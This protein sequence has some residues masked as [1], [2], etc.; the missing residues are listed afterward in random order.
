MAE[1][2]S[3]RFKIIAAVLLQTCLICLALFLIGKDLYANYKKLQI[4]RCEAMVEEDTAYLAETLHSLQTNVRELALVGELL[5]SEAP[6]S[7]DSVAKYAVIQN[8]QI[9][10]AAVGGGIWYIPY[11]FGQNRELACFYALRKENSTVL[12]TGFADRNYYY[13]GQGWY[14]DA[15]RAFVGANGR[16]R[17]KVVWSSAYVDAAGACSL[18]TTASAAILNSDGEI[19]GLATID[20]GLDDIAR[21]IASIRPTEGSITLLADVSHDNIL[22]LS[23]HEHEQCMLADDL[24][25]LRWFDADAPPQRTIRIDGNDYLSFARKF[26]NG[27]MVVVNVPE[28]ELFYTLNRGLL[29]TLISLLCVMFVASALIWTILNRFINQPV[30]QLCRAAEA[31]GAGDLDAIVPLGSRDELGSLSRS[32]AD[33]AA[34]LKK[35]IAHIEV[36]TAEKGRIEAELNIAHDI[37]AAMLPTVFPDRADCALATVMQPAREVGGDFYDFFFVEENRL[38]I[39]MADVSG[40][41]VPA[42]LFMAIAKA[43]VR[44]CIQTCADPGAALTA[45]NIQLSENNTTCMFVTAFAGILNLRTGEFHYANA[46]HNPFYLCEAGASTKIVDM[47]PGLPLAVMQDT[48]YATCTLRLLPNSV[49]FL[50]TDGVTEATNSAG[51]FF[52]QKRLEATLAACAACLPHDLS[53][54]IADVMAGLAIFACAA[55]QN[56]DITMLALG[57]TPDSQCD[58]AENEANLPEAHMA[59]FYCMRIFPAQVEALPDFMVLLEKAF[60][61]GTFTE[62]QRMRFCVAAEEIFVNIANYAYPDK[63]DAGTVEIL[64]EVSGIPSILQLRFTDFGEA[65]NPLNQPQPDLELPAKDRIPGGLGVFLARKGASSI[66]YVREFGKNILTM[67][68]SAGVGVSC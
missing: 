29:V 9:Q 45:A 16:N 48:E 5:L 51:E 7:L 26:D 34:N 53:R 2:H 20:W 6:D 3:V 13:P 55:C 24:N 37:Q 4:A 11:L 31:V 52:G 59:D 23:A 38:A 44:N 25:S 32:F 47:P 27:M 56:D 63:T 39:V 14:L 30:M 35:H 41:G 64:I 68:L 10:R 58:T 57:W 15:M 40:K 8:F 65:F 49:I 33:M 50:Y 61:A 22:S 66:R 19:A 28:K 12:D 18:M 1:F 54:F 21:E 43:L 60:A 42:A 62:R 67:T 17:R 36:I 46:G